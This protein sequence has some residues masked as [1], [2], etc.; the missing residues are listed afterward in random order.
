[1]PVIKRQAPLPEEGEYAGQARKVSQEYTK[2][3]I[4]ADGTKSEPIPIFRIPLYT[5]N[6]KQITTFAR[7]TENTGWVFEQMCK[8]GNMIPPD[9]AEFTI[10]CDDLENRV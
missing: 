3:K 6:G 10:S 1:M 4:N 2:P 8:S 5:H 9:G 7:V